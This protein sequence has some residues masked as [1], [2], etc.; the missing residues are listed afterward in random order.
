[1]IHRD[2]FSTS[3]QYFIL[4]G[5]ERPPPSPT[6][7]LPSPEIVFRPEHQKQFSQFNNNITATYTQRPNSKLSFSFLCIWLQIPP[8]NF[9]LPT[10]NFLSTGPRFNPQGE[11]SYVIS[12]NCHNCHLE[13]WSFII[14]ISVLSIMVH[15][16]NKK[17]KNHCLIFNCNILV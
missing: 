12:Q 5:R 14:L 13:L 11:K 6:P 4:V 7:M 16:L 9:V 2:P 1:M 8:N 10:V 17:I 3:Q 15:Y